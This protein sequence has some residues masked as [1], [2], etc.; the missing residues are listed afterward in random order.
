[1]LEIIFDDGT[2]FAPDYSQINY[3]RAI[4]TQITPLLDADGEYAKTHRNG[5][6]SFALDITFSDLDTANNFEEKS[7]TR[8]PVK[9]FDPNYSA[10]LTAI[11]TEISWKHNFVNNLDVYE[12]SLTLHEQKILKIEIS[13]Q[14]P[15]KED[16]QK[17]QIS[18]EKLNKFQHLQ[19]QMKDFAQKGFSTLT[20]VLSFSASALAAVEEQRQKILNIKE[21]GHSAFLQ[22]KNLINT[23]ISLPLKW[24]SMLPQKQTAA[25]VKGY[26]DLYSESKKMI[27][28]SAGADANALFY[29]TCAASVFVVCDVANNLSFEKQ[30]QN[31]LVEYKEKL[32]ETY[33]DFITVRA[34]DASQTLDKK[35]TAAAFI[36]KCL[37]FSIANIEKNLLSAKQKRILTLE[38]GTDIYPLVSQLY[39]SKTPAE[40][41]E[42]LLNFI[43]DNN[44]HGEKLFMLAPN[45]QVLYFV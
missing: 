36:E 13:K 25:L 15:T 4:L 41:E 22:T 2:K 18:E 32:Y 14:K 6:R 29:D 23:A 21:T 20:N 33:N 24:A 38:S 1:M 26:G 8:Q 10:Q 40:Y 45:T 5:G 27:S 12:F 19:G 44:L 35:E 39:P 7:K 31:F 28:T 17:T 30:R 9:I 34:N 11:I 16:L 43:A 37:L 42:N 3:K